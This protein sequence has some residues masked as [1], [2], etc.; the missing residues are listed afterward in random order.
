M[1]PNPYFIKALAFLLL[2][3]TLSSCEPTQPGS[4]KNDKIDKSD[5]EKFHLLNAELFK[6]LKVDD[7]KQLENM[8]SKEFIESTY[9]NRQVELVS[10]RAKTATYTLLDEY[11]VVNRYKDGDTVKTDTKGVNS[12]TLNFQGATHQMYMAFFT[13]KNLVN[14][15][16]ITAIYC[17]YDYGW[18]LSQLDLN[19]YTI[20]GKTAPELFEQAKES[21][22][23][24]YLIDALNISASVINCARPSS[25]WKYD[26]EPEFSDLYNKVLQEAT[27]RFRFPI[28]IKQVA[29][30]PR[31]IRI[32]NQTTP[33]GVFPMI[34]YM[35]AI[36]LKD[37]T[38][39]KQ[40]NEQI[41]KVIDQTLPGIDKNKKYIYYAAFND[42]PTGMK[43]VEH[44]DMTEKLN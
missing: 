20:N 2:V 21:Y 14:Q 29:T 35:S 27:A 30:H 7:V 4:W 36:K 10:N 16:M 26:N 19:P 43:T 23:K 9:K 15:Y 11:Y 42:L 13:P 33:D 28:A 17:K 22:Q 24:N 1:Q 12:H 25:V 31:I 3:F 32:F 39:L 44:F 6:Q 37:T 40:E 5:R 41:K 34:Y 38:A 18:K 8:M